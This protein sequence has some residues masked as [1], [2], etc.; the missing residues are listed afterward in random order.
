MSKQTNSEAPAADGEPAVLLE[1]VSHPMKR[2][3][4]KTA[5]AVLSILLAG[6][7]AGWI[8]EAPGLG[9]VAVILMF[10]SLA[11]FFLPTRYTLTES[12]VTV[13]TTTTTFSRPWSQFRS[14][15]ADKNGVLLSPFATQSRLENFR[16]LYVTFEENKER[17]IAIVREQVKAPELPD[18]LKDDTE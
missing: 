2:S 7:A 13:K 5:L 10:A 15:Y 12:G 6:V 4:G 18:A 16:G 8:M 1:W 14:F 17:V 11:K 3:P 9:I